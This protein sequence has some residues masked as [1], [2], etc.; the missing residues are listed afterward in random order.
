[1]RGTKG[2]LH[3]LSILSAGQMAS[4]GLNVL[5]LIFLAD[6][7][8]PH[9]FGVVQIGVTVMAYALI[10]AEW[11][12]MSLGIREVSRMDSLSSVRRYA[13]THLGLLTLQALVVAALGLLILPRLSF[14]SED[15]FVFRA[16]LLT[17]F[18]QIFM[19]S[20]VAVGLERLAWVSA[21]KTGRALFY[22]LFILLLWKPLVQWTG[23][24]G[25]QLVPLLFLA[26]MIL[27]N[28]VIG[29]PLAR[30]FGRT[31]WPTRPDKGEAMRRWRETAPLG[32]S[33]LV[34][35]ILL[36]I[37]I[38][39]LGLRATP[40]A[41][42]NYAAA[43]RIIFL[44]VISVEVLWAALLP[45][46]SRLFKQS[47]ARFN[48]AFNLYLGTVLA[49]LL[50]I[51]LGGALL[52][53]DLILAIYGDKFPEAGLV[54]RILSISYTML[55]VGTFL[56]NTLISEDRQSSYLPPVSLSALVALA[57]TF[58]LIPR[59]GGMGA[60]LG[61]SLSHLLLMT[62]LA[63]ILRKRFQLVLGQTLLMLIPALLL[64]ALLVFATHSLHV[65][66]RVALGAVLYLTLAVWPLLRLK[67]LC[68][69]QSPKPLDG[70]EE[71]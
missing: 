53:N 32:S 59:L 31:L 33:I 12:M 22:A 9:W 36:N 11:G 58:L 40:E 20:W 2:V 25:Q 4:Q 42:G 37:D 28:L 61:M 3:N 17:V 23:L 6:Q 7:L 43:S 16:Y 48:Q 27:G 8:G 38:I 21:A 41:V 67:R 47:E 5:A 14:F 24:P 52:G 71:S 30:W 29:I 62:T 69:F 49:G 56:G 55:A 51:A 26:A 19:L 1:M 44:L 70:P 35:R 39:M 54:F 45:R 68:H 57:G 46:F 18:P 66:Y 34:L 10:T 50:P 65:F 15:P 64:M 63:V 60:S 13:E